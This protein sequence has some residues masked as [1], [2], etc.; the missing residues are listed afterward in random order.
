MNTYFILFIVVL[1]PAICEESYENFAQKYNTHNWEYNKGLYITDPTESTEEAL[2][3][4]AYQLV[5]I[6]YGNFL[7]TLDTKKQSE[8][9][10]VLLDKYIKAEKNE[11]EDRKLGEHID[12]EM[13]RI[14]DEMQFADFQFY[15]KC[16][17]F[18]GGMLDWQFIFCDCNPELP[19]KK[20]IDVSMM[21]TRELSIINNDTRY[22]NLEYRKKLYLA[23][24]RSLLNIQYLYP[25]KEDSYKEISD[26]IEM[27]KCN[28][29]ISIKCPE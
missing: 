24:D 18:D 22:S 20:V 10:K 27:Y 9:E 4:Y 26:C 17:Y 13:K 12:D 1:K 14:L 28:F 2:R 21:I 16:L 25:D 19:K 8:A 15:K 5:Q 6:S 29:P 11:I 7:S 3:E 23:I